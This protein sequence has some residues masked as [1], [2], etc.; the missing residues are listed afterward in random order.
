MKLDGITVKA[1]SRMVSMIGVCRVDIG[2]R[3]GAKD[4]QSTN[5][6]QANKARVRGPGCAL[7]SYGVEGLAFL[8]LARSF[9]EIVSTVVT[10]RRCVSR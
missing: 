9:H 4:T 6:Q 10:S 2:C 1:S 8:A 7:S 3:D 5:N